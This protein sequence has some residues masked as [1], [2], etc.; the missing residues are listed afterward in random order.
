MLD[1]RSHWT[2]Y[3]K[4]LQNGRWSWLALAQQFVTHTGLSLTP[5]EIIEVYGERWSI[6][7]IFNQLK[8]S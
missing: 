3:Y 4:W 2:S 8:L 1:M 5:E 6:Q 7:S